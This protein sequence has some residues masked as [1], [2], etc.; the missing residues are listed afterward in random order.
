LKVA[1]D[2]AKALKVN[3]ATASALAAATV[4][5]DAAA[6]K[7]SKKPKKSTRT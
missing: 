3:N 1:L 5:F 4:D 7:G 2:D 6:G